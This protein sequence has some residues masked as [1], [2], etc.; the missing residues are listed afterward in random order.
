MSTALKII[1]IIAILFVT[2]LAAA[3][4]IG[5][6]WF[7]KNKDQL[8][9]MGTRAIAEGQ[10]WGESH[11]QAGCRDESMRRVKGCEGLRCEIETGVFL[12][13]C[14]EASAP[15][16][17]FCDGVPAESEILTTVKWRISECE[18]LGMEDSQACGRLLQGVQSH[19]HP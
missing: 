12:R 14:L 17:G 9:D 7:Q 11:D 2:F 3:G 13:S 8:K 15:S 10:A 6:L 18:K 1:L 16:E 4:V 19:C 5:Y